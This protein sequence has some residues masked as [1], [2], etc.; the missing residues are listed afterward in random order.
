M[1]TGGNN[2]LFFEAH[3]S[4][5]AAL[6]KLRKMP[7]VEYS[8]Q[9]RLFVSINSQML[10]SCLRRGIPSFIPFSQ[11]KN[12]YE[13]SSFPMMKLTSLIHRGVDLLSLWKGSAASYTADN[14]ERASLVAQMSALDV[15]MDLW[16]KTVPGICG[17]TSEPT[18]NASNLPQWLRPIIEHPGVPRVMQVHDN[19]Q[20]IFT[21]NLWRMMRMLVAR[22][23][24]AASIEM[25]GTDSISYMRTIRRMVEDTCTSILPIFITPIDT[26]PYANTVE[27][28]CGFRSYMAINPLLIAKACLEVLPATVESGARIAWIG[29]VHAFTLREFHKSRPNEPMIY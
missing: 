9:W 19:V 29:E 26:K 24:L 22:V 16:E 15:S 8:Y 11:I 10:T 17:F 23:L 25:P 14:A 6:L 2:A 12:F 18:P 5:L 20:L 28:V 21:S 1:S 4:G 13:N 7:A 3:A 27:E